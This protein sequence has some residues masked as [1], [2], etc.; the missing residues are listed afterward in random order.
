[1]F[2]LEHGGLISIEV[3]FDPLFAATSIVVSWRWLEKKSRT[4][5]NAS[6]SFPIQEKNKEGPAATSRHTP[7]TTQ[8]GKE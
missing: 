1:L 5:N 6:P 4:N 3:G 8:Y 7:T 2:S